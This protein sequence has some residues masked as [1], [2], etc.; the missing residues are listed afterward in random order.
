MSN[1]TQ[2]DEDLCCYAEKPI[3]VQLDFNGAVDSVVK[4][5]TVRVWNSFV[6]MCFSRVCVCRCSL[7]ISAKQFQII[8]DLVNSAPADGQ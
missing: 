8:C 7:N 5:H 3:Q 2:Y 6:G 4:C 1:V